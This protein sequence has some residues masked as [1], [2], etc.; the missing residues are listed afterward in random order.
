MSREIIP[1]MLL[2]DHADARN[3]IFFDP[4]TEELV[5]YVTQADL[6]EWLTTGLSR[7]EVIATHTCGRVAHAVGEMI[8]FPRNLRAVRS[9]NAVEIYREAKQRENKT[10]AAKRAHDYLELN[11]SDASRPK[12]N[13]LGKT[14]S[15]SWHPHGTQKNGGAK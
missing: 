15:E 14:E 7:C 13:G 1:T 4:K 2:P 6:S 10:N 8:T 5:R 12:K 9:E 3:W 11:T